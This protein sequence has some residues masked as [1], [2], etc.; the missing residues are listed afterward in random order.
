M[1]TYKMKIKRDR[2]LR[3]APDRECPVI[4]DKH[5]EILVCIPWVMVILLHSVSQALISTT[6]WHAQT[7]EHKT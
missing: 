6:P 5:T 7:G 1:T 4:T 2:P 3:E